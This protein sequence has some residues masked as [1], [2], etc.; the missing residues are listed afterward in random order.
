[1]K[2][3]LVCLFL[4][5]VAGCPKQETTQLSD[6]TVDVDSSADVQ[7]LDVVDAG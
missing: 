7:Q 4:V 1:M 6:A 3:L 5:C 2:K